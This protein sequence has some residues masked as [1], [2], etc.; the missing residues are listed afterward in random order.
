MEFQ[1]SDEKPP[2]QSAQGIPDVDVAIGGS[3]AVWY[4]PAKSASPSGAY[5]LT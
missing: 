2:F 5:G 3:R 4:T 1:I